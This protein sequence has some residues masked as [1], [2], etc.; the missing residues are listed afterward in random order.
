MIWLVIGARGQLGTDLM[1]VLGTRAV[2]LDIPEIDITD[3]SSVASTIRDIAPDVV[4]NCAA[5][6]AVDAA[7]ADEATAMAINGNGVAHIAAACP[8]ARLVQISTD[9]VFDGTSTSPYA[10]EATPAPRS[11]YGRTK[12][13]GERAALSH[14]HAY[15]LRTAWLYGAHG[16]NFVKTMLHLERTRDTVSVVDDQVGQ[17]TWSMD[18]ARQ[19]DLLVRADAPSGVYHATNS[20]SASWYE[21]ARAIFEGAGADPGRVVPTTTAAFPRPAPR[22]ANS[23]LGHQRWAQAGL[24]PMRPWDDALAEA[25]PAILT[26]TN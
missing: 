16:Q 18:L 19:I 15:V 26:S 13:A 5:Y 1:T 8:G 20:G 21:F 9:Y 14:P 4:V 25:L 22:P 11:A 17:P 23:V 10:E 2:G 6:T 24:E 12:L 7:E 3:P